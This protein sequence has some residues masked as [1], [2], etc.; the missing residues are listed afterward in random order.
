VNETS[1]IPIGTGVGAK[2]HFLVPAE[3]GK[4]SCKQRDS[5]RPIECPGSEPAASL[6]S[7]LGATHEQIR[8][9]A[10]FTFAGVSGAGSFSLLQFDKVAS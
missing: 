6:S 9:D 2:L 5:L 3:R 8:M 4:R 10:G 1:D 7:H